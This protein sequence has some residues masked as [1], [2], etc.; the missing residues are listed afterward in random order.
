MTLVKETRGCLSPSTCSWE[1]DLSV[2]I[3]AVVAE[4]K[5]FLLIQTENIIAMT[6]LILGLT[7]ASIPSV[8]FW[9]YALGTVPD[10]WI[11]MLIRVWI[12]NSLI[13]IG[14]TLLLTRRVHDLF[15][16]LPLFALLDTCSNDAKPFWSHVVSS[17]FPSCRFSKHSQLHSTGVRVLCQ[18]SNPNQ[19]GLL[20]TLRERWSLKKKKNLILSF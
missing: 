10:G 4:L 20:E 17:L 6:S 15:T 14:L 7:A 8:G 5:Q 18:L 9:Q 3:F 16:C 13:L 2:S 1:L 12:R 19:K 11:G